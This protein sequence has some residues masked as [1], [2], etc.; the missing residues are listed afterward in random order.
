MKWCFFLFFFFFLF[1]PI[2]AI[3]RPSIHI[4]FQKSK[5]FLFHSP[6]TAVLSS[7]RN[8]SVKIV[9]LKELQLYEDICLFKVRIDRVPHYRETVNNPICLHWQTQIRLRVCWHSS[10]IWSIDASLDLLEQS[11][12]GIRESISKKGFLEN[13]RSRQLR[14]F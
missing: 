7:R 3:I 1:L 8:F 4:I 12:A 11:F 2:P 10:E 9:S 5:D 14:V 6:I 13:R